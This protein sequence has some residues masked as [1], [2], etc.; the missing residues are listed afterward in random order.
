MV[1]ILDSMMTSNVSFLRQKHFPVCLKAIIRKGEDCNL[2]S[3]SQAGAYYGRV[4]R[5]QTGEK[6]PFLHQKMLTLIQAY[7]ET[8][9]C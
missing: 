7:E 6:M 1:Y 5:I 2:H 9:L 4:F 8:H 3:M